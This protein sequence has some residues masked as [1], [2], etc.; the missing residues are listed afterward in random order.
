[1]NHKEGIKLLTGS[2]FGKFA[3]KRLVPWTLVQPLN[4][5]CQAWDAVTKR[6]IGVL[7]QHLV[8]QQ[9]SSLS[10]LIERADLPLQT[11]R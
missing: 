1:V 5:L 7:D 4:Y 10:S 3:N 8:F 6:L 9:Q 2:Y 11:V